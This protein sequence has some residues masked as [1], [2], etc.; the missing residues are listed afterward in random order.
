VTRTILACLVVAVIASATTATA[1]QLVTSRDIRN[2]TIRNVDLR[3]GAVT[4]P[5]LAPEI[6][7]LLQQIRSD[8]EDRAVA[9]AKGEKGDPGPPGVRGADGAPGPQGDKGDKGDPGPALSSGNW[10][11]I[12]RNTIG[13]PVAQLRSGPGEPPHGNGSLNL[14]VADDTEKI[15]YGNELDFTGR[16]IVDINQVGLSVYNGFDSSK[17]YVP[18]GIAFEIDPNLDA[19]VNH[20]SL[21]YL[22]PVPAPAER[23]KWITYNADGDEPTTTSGWFFTNGLT[24]AATGCGQ[25]AGQRFCSWDEVQTAAPGALVLFSVA[26]TKGPDTPFT[27][28]VDGLR[29]GGTLVDLEETGAFPRDG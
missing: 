15:A 20:S 3:E 19:G 28:A 21:V 6:Q 8:G 10:G 29:V 22:P 9:G 12:N 16:P 1:A 7:A 26:I 23:N 13:S 27:G 2:G 17:S 18:P 4:M 5:R 25:G 11:V 24:A 14:L